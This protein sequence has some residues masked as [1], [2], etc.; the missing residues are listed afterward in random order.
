MPTFTFAPSRNVPVTLPRDNGGATVMSMNGWQ[1]TSKPTTPYQRKFKVTLHGM[2]WYL[3]ATTGLYD[4]TTNPTFNARALEIF[5]EQNEQWNPF[6]FPH[7]HFGNL[8]CRFAAPLQVPEAIPN[9]N[10]L[11]APFEM[12]LIHHNPGYT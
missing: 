10:G 7:Q 1:F 9:S 3:N 5:Y 2:R 11:I 12:T 6:V 4:T 8:D